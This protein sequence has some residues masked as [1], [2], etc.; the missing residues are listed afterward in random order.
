MITNRFRDFYGKTLIGSGTF[1]HVYKAVKRI[2]GI[3]YAIK[4]SKDKIKK[5]TRKG[6]ILNKEI[7]ALSVLGT[8]LP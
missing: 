2:E 3:F 7:C 1:G 4:V 5:N 8:V 6:H